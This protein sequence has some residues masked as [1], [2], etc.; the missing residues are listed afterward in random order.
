M[1][2]RAVSRTADDHRGASLLDAALR[3]FPV[4]GYEGTSIEA[5]TAEAGLGAA[6]FDLCFA[7]KR[8]L[9]GALRKRAAETLRRLFAEA[10]ASGAAPA[11][12][13]AA[14]GAAW[15]RTGLEALVGAYLRFFDEHRAL[16][17][18]AETLEP[19]GD[20]AIGPV[21]PAE[22]ALPPLL[23]AGAQALLPIVIDAFAESDR[24]PNRPAP[25][26]WEAALALWA[27][28]DGVLLGAVRRGEDY[29]GAGHER[30][31]ARALEIML[32]GLA[33]GA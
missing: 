30:V 31:A 21:A 7:S 10:L 23:E 33:G 5:L 11:S 27:M 20:E 15:L 17:V 6:D 18:V 12:D 28:L 26:P 2:E 8:E 19:E 3:L 1:Q 24:V 22:L 25:D 16:Y 14:A 32:E 9:L 29:R 4:H 13:P